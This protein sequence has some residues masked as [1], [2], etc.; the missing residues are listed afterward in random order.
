ME[1]PLGKED[2]QQLKKLDYLRMKNLIT[3]EDYNI[4]KAKLFQKQNSQFTQ[5]LTPKDNDSTNPT[6]SP[7]I[8]VEKV[9]KDQIPKLD[10]E[11]SPGK[12]HLRSSSIHGQ[13]LSYR[14]NRELTTPRTTQI[15]KLDMLIRELKGGNETPPMTKSIIKNEINY[16]EELKKKDDEIEILK[17]RIKKLED[18]KVT[19]EE[20]ELQE[21]K[22]LYEKNLLG[23]DSA[24]KDKDKEIKRLQKKLGSSDLK[25][26]YQEEII[27]IDKKRE[28]MLVGFE[29]LKEEYEKKIEN[30]E[31]ELLQYKNGKM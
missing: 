31:K 12:K 3:E 30:L 29:V 28:M 6:L 8:N 23:F 2:E 20:K 25:K 1:N 22:E 5:N 7:T 24:L 14:E 10:L 4:K 18:R 11:S 26:E 16:E 13:P 21:L 9:D 17:V 27:H 15:N 19:V